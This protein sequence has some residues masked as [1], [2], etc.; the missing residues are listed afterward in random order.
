MSEEKGNFSKILRAY[1]TPYYEVH[2][3]AFLFIALA[4]GIGNPFFYVFLEYFTE[5]QEFLL[6][7]LVVSA[8]F[9]C[10]LFFP[11]QRKLK[12]TE[13]WIVEL[14]FLIVLPAFFTY[15]L[16]LNHLNEYWSMSLLLAATL[17]A[18]FADPLKGLILYPIAYISVFFFYKFSFGI[19]DESMT[20]VYETFFVTY[21]IYIVVG[22]L[23][24]I[25]RSGFIQLEEKNRIIEANKIELEK[26]KQQ[27]EKANQAKTDFLA[28]MSHEIRTPLNSIIGFSQILSEH[29]QEYNFPE[30]SQ[31]FLSHIKNAGEHL[32]ELV[33]NILDLSKIEAGK[34]IVNNQA[35]SLT[36]IIKGIYHLYLTQAQNR[37]LK[38]NYY[39][40]ERLPLFI[41]SDKIKLHQILTNLIANAIKFSRNGE[42]KLYARHEGDNISISISDQGVGISKERQRAIFN[43]FEQEDNTT[44][45]RFGG[46]G[47]GLAIS[48]RLVELMGGSIS[49]ESR[50]GIGST[51]TVV[52]PLVSAKEKDISKTQVPRLNFNSF[53]NKNIL[54]VE[55]DIMNQ[56]VIKQ[57]LRKMNFN[58]QVA[59]HGQEALTM[60]KNLSD[61]ALRPDLIFMDLHMPIMDG[62][63]ALAQIRSIAQFRDIPVI[64]LTAD[65][66]QEQK[67][68][69]LKKGFT[70]YL[71]KP[72][73][74]KELHAVLNQF[75]TEDQSV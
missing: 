68:Q 46:S 10:L 57:M 16:L 24:A 61:E 73:V 55:D 72:I 5:N 53:S 67:K 19:P 27:A 3:Q 52:I 7:R 44:T 48:K 38:F 32:T 13:I 50:Q 71:T 21:L 17:Y 70:E 1:T 66:L 41:I 33:N 60:L 69:G 59:N 54:I 35:F 8:L 51:F 14:I 58:I 30:E 39:I 49:L 11:K 65:A 22:G 34:M 63:E 62:I 42:I 25:T 15:M 4:G 20:R 31:A 6:G 75:L 43:A 74:Q 18:L 23:H 2:Q 28:N 26:S 37:G 56:L 45:R 29:G 64:A 12:T 40:D 36:M 47:L 9:L